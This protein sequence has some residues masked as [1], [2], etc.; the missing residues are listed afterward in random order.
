MEEYKTP[1]LAKL[2]DGIEHQGIG[3]KTIVLERE[4]TLSYALDMPFDKMTIGLYNF[5]NRRMDLMSSDNDTMKLYYGHV[6]NLGYFVSEDEIDGEIKDVTW[7]EASEY[8][9]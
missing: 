9:V 6:G 3:G 8:L 7:S 1:K 5:V 2:I 4:G